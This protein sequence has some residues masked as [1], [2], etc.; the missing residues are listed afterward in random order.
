M[1]L[2]RKI[3]QIRLLINKEG[4]ENIEIREEACKILDGGEVAFKNRMDKYNIGILHEEV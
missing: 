4:L 3:I 1:L 2:L